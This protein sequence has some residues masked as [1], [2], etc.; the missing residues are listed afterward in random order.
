MKL[1]SFH[2]P[3]ALIGECYKIK[4]VLKNLEAV[5]IDRLRFRA[6]I[7]EEDRAA[8]MAGMS[9]SEFRVGSPWESWMIWAL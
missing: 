5:P 9:I 6:F 1:E 3:P 2:N 4:C 7:T 8:F